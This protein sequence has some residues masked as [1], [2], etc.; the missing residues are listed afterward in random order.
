MLPARALVPMGLLRTMP[1]APH[2]GAAWVSSFVAHGPPAGRESARQNRSQPAL[3]PPAVAS[4]VDRGLAPVY[5][6]ARI[7][8]GVLKPNRDFTTQT[9]LAFRP[10]FSPRRS[11]CTSLPPQLEIC[12][13]F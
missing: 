4:F 12:L 10:A 3:F 8:S 7:P 13:H 5:G 1:S 2:C 6:V 9:S 11:A